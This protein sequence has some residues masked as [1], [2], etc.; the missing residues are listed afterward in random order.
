MLLTGI[1]VAVTLVGL[2]EAG[3]R[4]LNVRQQTFVPV[5]LGLLQ[6]EHEGGDQQTEDQY[7]GHTSH[8]VRNG[9]AIDAVEDGVY[10]EGSHIVREEREER[11]E[12]RRE[13]KMR[14]EKKR[15]RGR[16]RKRKRS[17]SSVSGRS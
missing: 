7:E 1:A 16:K 6:R 8:H 14:R 10:R 13:E 9:Q 15:G 12:K 17:Y 4:E 3:I 11:E 2:D 5:E